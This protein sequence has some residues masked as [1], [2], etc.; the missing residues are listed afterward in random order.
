MRL[1]PN[2]TVVATFALMERAVAAHK[3]LGNLVQI[4]ISR[5]VETGKLGVRLSAE[6]PVFLCWG[7]SPVD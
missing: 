4:G 7:T 1:R 2:G 3:R 6:N 5:G